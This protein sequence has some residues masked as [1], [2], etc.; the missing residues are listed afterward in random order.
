MFDQQP[1]T[2]TEAAILAGIE[3]ARPR[4][5]GG[6]N[7]DSPLYVVRDGSGDSQIIDTRAF[8]TEYLEHPRRKI[9]RYDVTRVDSFVDYLDR[10]GN[11][12]TEITVDTSTQIVSALLDGHGVEHAGHED[13]KLV[14][15]FPKSDE[16]TLWL[17]RNGKAM[18]QREFAE[19][20]EDNLIDIAD[21]DA[22]TMLEIVSSLSATTKATFHSAHRLSDGSTEF[23]WTEETTAKA[24]NKAGRLD[25]PARFTIAV[26][27]FRGEERVHVDARFRYRINAGD[28]VMSYHLDRPGD[29]ARGAFEANLDNLT[30][31]LSERFPIYVN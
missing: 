4:Q 19:F 27:V 20:V 24:G 14:L 12:Q 11:E 18:T 6:P 7:A 1:Q 28:L 30:G 3:S 22:A 8:D 26:P 16:W 9:G 5:I 25:I 31:R 13:H 23:E 29:V 17:A 2:D 10:H 21:P 15:S